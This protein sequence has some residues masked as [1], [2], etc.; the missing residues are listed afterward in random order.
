[1]SLLLAAVGLYGVMSYSV[2]QRR[3]EMGIRVA[4]GARRADVLRLV[5]GQGLSLAAA[6]IAAGLA[7][8]LGVTRLVVSLLYEVSPYDPWA[9]FGVPL[10][11]G[12][13][14]V[15]ACAVPAWRA[16]SADPT[17]ALRSE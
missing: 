6:G 4:L 11:L 8:S 1:L 3:R 5:V 9:F 10:L 12:A 17:E 7:L 13:A 2:S 14:A 16:G 15:L